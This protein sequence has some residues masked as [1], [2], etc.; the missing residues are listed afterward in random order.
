[1]IAICLVM[2]DKWRSHSRAVAELAARQHG[3]VSIRQLEALGISRDA[4]ARAARDG[5]AHRVFPGVYAIGHLDLSEHGHCLAAVLASGPNAVLSHYSA[6][7]LWG[8]TR[9]E[10]APYEV[11]A[12]IPRRRKPPRIVVHYA[13]HLSPVDRAVVDNIPVT[14]VPRVFLDLAARDRKGRLRGYMERAEELGLLDLRE[15]H[16]LLDRTRGHHGWGRLRRAAAFYEVP[17]EFTRSKFERRFLAAVKADRL[18]H[19]AAN[20]NLLGYELDLYWEEQR[21]AVELD[22]YGTHGTHEAF[23]RD[24]VR[25]EDLL[26]LGVTMIRVTDIRFY[27]EP[28]AVISRVRQLLE[29]RTRGDRHLSGPT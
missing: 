2:P 19:P 23:E 7:W 4:A 5:L 9:A 1:M 28:E 15:I 21:F 13:R 26:V 18:P 16:E 20:Y 22:T 29:E 24:R 14:A 3:V 6:G 17:A 12:P 25:A 27:R 10:P 8:V 11:T